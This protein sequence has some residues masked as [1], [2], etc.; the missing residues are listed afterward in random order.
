M[1]S[2]DLCHLHT[3]CHTSAFDGLGKPAEFFEKAAEL[4]QSSLSI[5]DHGSLRGLY[6][7]SVAAEKTGVKLIPGAELYLVDDASVKGF[8]DEEKVDAK[9]FCQTWGLDLRQYLKEEMKTRTDRDHVTVW[10]VNDIGLRNLY[11]LTAE[12]WT[13]GF[14][15]KPR[16]D[17]RRL[18]EHSEG[19]AVSSGC[20]NGVVAKL[21]RKKEGILEAV[22]RA[23]K[24]AEVFGDRF[25]VE[26]MPHVPETDCIGLANRL[27]RL[28]DSL[29]ATVIATQDAHYP[30][31]EDANAQEVL[32]CIHTRSKMDAPDRFCFDERQYWLKSRLELE[33]AFAEKLPTLDPRIW[34]KAMDATVAFAERCTAKVARPKAGAYLVAPPLPEGV[35]DYDQW[36]RRLC[37]Q[38][39]ETR[40]GCR[41][42]GLGPDYIGRLRHELQTIKD[43]GFSKYFAAIWE[44][45]HWGRTQGILC[46]PGRGSGAGSFV[47]YLLGVTDLDPIR[48]GLSFDRFLAPG[49]VDL[50]DID[51]DFE[52]LRRAEVID[53]LRDLYGAENVAQISTHNI[54]G[55]KQ[56]ANDLARIFSIP[57]G[58]VAPISAMI[59]EGY[60]E[61]A[62]TEESLA[63]VLE[64]T[65]VGREFAGKYPDFAQVA[66]R[67]EGN[68]R[69][70][71]LHAS[72][73]V[74]SPVPLADF[75]PL[76]TAKEDDT[77]KRALTIAYDMRGVEQQG[78]VKADILGLTTLSMLQQAFAASGSRPEEID[79]EDPNVLDAFTLGRL[80]GIFQYDTSSAR[81]LTKG[82]RFT[83][84]ADTAVMTALNR[85][86]PAKSGLSRQFLL[87][88]A[89]PS[90]VPALHPVYDHATEETFGIPV[91]QEQVIAIARGFGYS[92]EEADKL[93][94]K[95]GKKLGLSDEEEKFV[96]GA[97]DKGMEQDAALALWKDLVGFGAYS[98]NK[99]H[100]YCYGALACWGMWLKVY[101]PG[102][103]YSA[104]LT[105]ET[106]PE[107][108]MRLAAEARAFGFPV[109]T[110]SVNS[111][112]SGF[113]FEGS[114]IVGAVADLKGIGEKTATAIAKGAPYSDLLDFHERTAGAGER[115]TSKTFAILCMAGA[116]RCMF[117]NARFLA[118]NAGV[119]WEQLRAGRQPCLTFE[120]PDYTDDEMAEKAGVVWP[121]AV[122]LSGHSAFEGLLEALRGLM[123]REVLT[124]G[125]EELTNPG[126][127]CVFA[128]LSKYQTFPGDK[129]AVSGRATFCSADGEEISARIDSEVM[130]SSAGAFTSVNRPIV[131][132]LSTGDR[133][134]MAIERAWLLET[135]E[136]ALF[137]KKTRPRDIATTIENAEEGEAFPAEGTLIRKR[138]HLT[139]KEQ[140]MATL[141]IVS[142]FGAAKV[143]VFPRRL[144]ADVAGLSLGDRVALK[145]KKLSGQ[146]VCLTD[147]PISFL[148]N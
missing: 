106:K 58:E 23:K 66:R 93:R 65:Q 122:S 110:P 85:P 142:E 28:A 102:A 84:F 100:S 75:I 20:P 80:A 139:K 45:R 3:H 132:F 97:I 25:L 54:L 119:V 8:T 41:P 91:Y 81:R 51:L 138:H 46:G 18:I 35:A 67:L 37:A 49:R 101:H 30:H 73:V 27:V 113:R 109:K 107:A 111:V 114:E 9:A 89:D 61:E 136:P 117:P 4:G 115:I 6:E 120:Q 70:V 99:A 44:V 5:T 148:P 22:S 108:Q 31:E 146:A 135:F 90:R 134:G 63:R 79:L 71:G 123:K 14:Y 126:C 129:G 105:F 13:T 55:G 59:A 40:Y 125:E 10:A 38:G 128:I 143:L 92:P 130:D 60:E 7:C 62:K 131:C 57:S 83:R 26:I 104:A 141:T 2:D 144:K 21:L 15:H 50:P 116:F 78:L 74:M 94:K 147:D 77:G 32:L 87:R 1:A 56:A 118:E 19:L 127:R 53:H 82:Y 64:T 145:V 133:G 11:R 98:F 121:L 124:P 76:E 29:G 52:S 42:S 95:I 72:G 86:G 24:L 137:S 16:T 47:C 69:G 48:Y 103:F 96:K 33:L 17:I 88:S 12:S 36:L 140:A 39:I 34:R 112:G 43:L 68:L